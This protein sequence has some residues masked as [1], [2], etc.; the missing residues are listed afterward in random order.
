MVP[1]RLTPRLHRRFDSTSCVDA[2]SFLAGLSLQAGI[3]E[4]L[5]GE[6][7]LKRFA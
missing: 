2:R 4:D 7:D 1:R 5:L 6:G 3:T